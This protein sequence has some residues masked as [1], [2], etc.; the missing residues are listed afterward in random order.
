MKI[1]HTLAT[2][3]FDGREYSLN[4]RNLLYQL[5]SALTIRDV[6][7]PEQEFILITDTKGKNLIDKFNFPYSSINTA[8]DNWAYTRPVC[9]VSYKLVGFE[10]YPNEEVIHLDNDVFIKKRLPEYTEVLVQSDEGNFPQYHKDNIPYDYYPHYIY[11]EGTTIDDYTHNYNPGVIGFKAD[12]SI[13]DTYVNTYHTILEL[14]NNKLNHLQE[15]DPELRAKI[16]DQAIC[17]ILEE[18]LLYNL[19]EDNNVN[20]VEVLD[21][22]I[23]GQPMNYN[24]DR[25]NISESLQNLLSRSYNHWVELG[26]IHP[27]NKKE[28]Q[29]DYMVDL[30]GNFDSDTAT[31]FAPN[32]KQEITAFLRRR[33]GLSPSPTDNEI[34]L[35][36]KYLILT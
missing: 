11:P 19:C 33:D 27:F 6:Y 23:V 31:T 24:L 10:Q 13:R 26:Y 34:A 29:K 20:V 14:N 9:P 4:T 15:T 35:S 3:H 32:F 7:G 25:S 1:I 2:D 36:L 8:L 16:N 18:S 28:Y 12:C 17:G 21:K 5:I 22:A 30:I